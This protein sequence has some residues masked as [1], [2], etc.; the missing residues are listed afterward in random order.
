MENLCSHSS[1]WHP[2]FWREHVNSRANWLFSTEIASPFAITVC[3]IGAFDLSNLAWCRADVATVIFAFI[4]VIIFAKSVT[5]TIPAWN[6]H[7]DNLEGGASGTIITTT[8]GSTMALSGFSSVAPFIAFDSF[9]SAKNWRWCRFF[10]T[11]CFTV[12]VAALSSSVAESN[13]RLVVIV[14]IGAYDCS[15]I[16]CF[17]FTDFRSIAA[18]VLRSG[19]AR[20]PALIFRAVYDILCANQRAFVV[21]NHRHRHIFRAQLILVI[22]NLCKGKNVGVPVCFVFL[23]EFVLLYSAFILDLHAGS[24]GSHGK[25]RSECSHFHLVISFFNW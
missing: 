11:K 20:A 24:K 19:W 23:K 3:L 14:A 8:I 9:E 21:F 2:R 5:F 7:W 25:H 22:L 17:W 18:A 1:L 16:A 15:S 6:F 13:T 12:I 10:G 4:F